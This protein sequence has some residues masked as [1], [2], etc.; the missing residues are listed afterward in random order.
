MLAAHPT[1]GPGATIPV[2]LPETSTFIYTLRRSFNA[3]A[4]PFNYMETA[5]TPHI[6]AA[7]PYN[8]VY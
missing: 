8:E 3:S 4:N 5:Q 7:K 2:V 6:Y 1:L